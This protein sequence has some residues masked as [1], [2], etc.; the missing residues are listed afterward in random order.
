MNSTSQTF[1]ELATAKLAQF[2][3]SAQG[4]LEARQKAVDSLVQPI[5]ESLTKVDGKLGEIEKTRLSAYSSLDTQLRALIDSHL[6]K[7]HNETANLVKALRQPT[8]RG[9]WG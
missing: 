6:P 8:V 2:Q 3:E 1:L 5:K 7:L 4:D 9:R